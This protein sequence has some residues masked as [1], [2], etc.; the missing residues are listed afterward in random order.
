MT[1]KTKVLVAA[2]LAFIAYILRKLDEAPDF[3]ELDDH[4]KSDK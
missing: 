4:P 3:I 2:R 1:D